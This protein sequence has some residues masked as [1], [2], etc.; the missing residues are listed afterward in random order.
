MTTDNKTRQFCTWKKPLTALILL[1]I[2][3]ELK[4]HAMPSC[5]SL[6]L[7]ILIKWS[8]CKVQVF[9]EICVNG[10]PNLHPKLVVIYHKKDHL[11]NQSYGM[12]LYTFSS[13]KTTEH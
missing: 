3:Q 4:L 5:C 1:D 10:Q 6:E 12:H 7:S 2:K 9:R 11:T 8:S 13:L